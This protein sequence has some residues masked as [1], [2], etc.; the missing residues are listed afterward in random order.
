MAF[1]RSE[2]IARIS[3]VVAILAA[4]LFVAWRAGL[5]GLEDRGRLAAAIDRA[6]SVPF[7]SAVFLGTYAVAA[8][9]GVPVTPFTL[10]GGALFGPRWGIVLNWSAE[11]LAAMLA[12]ATVRATGIHASRRA[13]DAEGAVEALSLGHGART[14]FRL[15]L[16]PVAPFSLLNLGAA[17]SGMSWPDYLA[18]T[19]VGIIPLT[20]IY[21][22]SASELIAGVVGS[23]G[24]ALTLGLASAIVLIILSFLPSVL[25]RLGLRKL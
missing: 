8:A 14:L 18:A 17:L 13:H 7:I 21:T 4:V 12:F 22:V 10:I 23:G 5:F 24:R 25:A 2:Q 20:V 16:V 6:R 11:M 1:R 9:A 3:I 19:S 15:R